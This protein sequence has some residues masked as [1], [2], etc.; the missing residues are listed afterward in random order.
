[1]ANK[2]MAKKRREMKMKKKKMFGL[3]AIIFMLVTSSM[4]IGSSATQTIKSSKFKI[5]LE[6]SSIELTTQDLFVKVD[7]IPKEEPIPIIERFFSGTEKI[8]DTN[9]Y[10]SL[11]FNGYEDHMPPWTDSYAWAEPPDGANTYMNKDTGIGKVYPAQIPNRETRAGAG[12]VDQYYK[13][14]GLNAQ[15]AVILKEPSW[16]DMSIY[17]AGICEVGIGIDEYDPDTGD[18]T[19][20]WDEVVVAGDYTG[21]LDNVGV[22]CSFRQNYIY[23]VACGGFVFREGNAAG[24]I[25]EL[26]IKKIRWGWVEEEPEIRLIDPVEGGIYVRGKKL[27]V[28]PTISAAIL[29]VCNGIK[30]IAETSGFVDHV[31]FT[32]KGITVTDEE[33]S[34]NIW[35]GTIYGAT[36]INL[37]RLYA[38]ARDT[39]DDHIDSDSALLFK[40]QGS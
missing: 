36:K 11:T 23:S 18:L 17:P 9:I 7:F 38:H 29:L 5:D 35:S 13:F 10:Q 34:G 24:A 14:T 27:F 28:H 33:P 1:M 31:V 26:R 6:K 20:S 3:C 21:Y 12:I 19:N 37:D 15:G 32:Y 39:N 22:Q 30:C 16:V 25:N 40:I 4:L 2:I 8:D